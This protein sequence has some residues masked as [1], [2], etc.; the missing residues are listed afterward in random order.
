MV[1][2]DRM[3]AAMVSL[4]DAEIPTM[5]DSRASTVEPARKTRLLSLEELPRFLSNSDF[6]R[7]E[8]NQARQSAER[9]WRLHNCR[10]LLARGRG[11]HHVRIAKRAHARTRKISI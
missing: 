4:E 6:P 10:A 9:I 7:R 1:M 5:E 3:K 2:S 8:S 11:F